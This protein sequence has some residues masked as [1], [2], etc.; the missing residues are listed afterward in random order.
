MTPETLFQGGKD[1]FLVGVRAAIDSVE[2]QSLKGLKALEQYS[3]LSTDSMGDSI[4]TRVTDYEDDGMRAV[5][6]N[7]SVA[8]ISNSVDGYNRAAGQP[9]PEVAVS[10]GYETEIIDPDKQQAKAFNVPEERE[11]KEARMYKSVLNRAR[12]LMDDINRTNI[13]DPFELINLA[14]SAASVLP[15]RFYARGN[16]GLAGGQGVVSGNIAE[17]LIS[18][19][20]ALAASSSPSTFSNAVLANGNSMPLSDVALQSAR[21]LGASFV[22]DVGNP[23]PR[24]GGL[25]DILIPPA[26][27]LVKLAKQLEGSE[28]QISTNEN[29]IN[30]HK[31]TLG[32]IIDSPYLLKS[33]YVSTVSNKFAWE[34]VDRTVRDPETGTGFVC[35]TFVPLQSKVHRNESIDSIVYQLKQ[36]L[37]FTQI[38][39]RSIVGSL[40]DNNA[41]SS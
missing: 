26:N 29:Q 32:R 20:H 40:G 27:G 7:I 15:S 11:L 37:A 5:W 12:L 28:W 25:V 14:Y 23:S 4:Y 39:P 35:I 31:G 33:Q 16:R 36:E 3:L 9:Y 41:Y 8:G 13:K 30:V 34:L 22:D 1:V 10:R 6:R 21:E 19:I 18:T 38:D 17:P 24:M 2:D